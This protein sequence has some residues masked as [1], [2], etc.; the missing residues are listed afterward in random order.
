MSYQHIWA[1]AQEN[2]TLLHANN[3]V[4][5]QPWHLDSLIS[6]FVIGFLVVLQLN[7]LHTKFL[8]SSQSL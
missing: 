4:A 8:Y 1:S 7:L 6:T 3:K 5:D 2:L